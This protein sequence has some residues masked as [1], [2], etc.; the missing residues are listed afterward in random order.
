MENNNV[1]IRH[2]TDLHAWQEAKLL[3]VLT[4]KATSSFPA[5]EQFGLTSQTRR[6]AVSVSANIA[7]GFAR[8]TS[9]DKRGFYQ[10][11]LASLSELESHMLI[12]HEL[13]FVTKESLQA[14]RTQIE[15]AG[16]LLTGLL[17]SASD[18]I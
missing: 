1:K 18:R 8:R 5:E 17:R 15:R 6:A 11:A 14:L 2:F 3:A 12:A 7:E 16:K 4:Y 13:T 9:K 10:T